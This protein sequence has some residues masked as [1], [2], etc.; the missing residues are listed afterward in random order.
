MRLSETYA[1]PSE[2]ALL[3]DFANTLD[4]RTYTEKG[5]AHRGG[6]E[7]G[8]APRLE[9]WMR[10]HGLLRGGQSVGQDEHLA[11]L[12]LRDALRAFLV[13]APTDRAANREVA[14][15][16]TVASRRFPLALAVGDGGVVAL[17]PG[18]GASALGRV[19]A[20][21]LS[22]AATDRLARLKAC[23]SEA[24][25]WVFFDRSKPANRTWCSSRL[26]GNREKT[27]AYRTRLRR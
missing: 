24:C 15:R 4:E 25:H 12:E 9:A 17:E 5:E 2:L 18:L 16:L 19:L 14:Q 8:T 20:H 13:A 21:L 3:Y 27:R 1:V 11:A 26:C 23:A 6:D 7:I 22:L 10:D